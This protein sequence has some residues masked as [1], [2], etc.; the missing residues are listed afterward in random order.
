MMAVMDLLTDKPDWHIKVFDDEIA[1]K[2]RQEA[3]AWPDDDLRRRLGVSDNCPPG[4]LDRESV[5]YVSP[6]PS[7]P[8]P[9]TLPAYRVTVH[10]RAAP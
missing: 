4:L 3:L 7:S 8:T 9:T 10:P 1:E 6:R 2:W 5:D